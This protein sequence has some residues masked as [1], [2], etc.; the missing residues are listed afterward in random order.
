MFLKT[1]SVRI[2]IVFLL[3]LHRFNKDELDNETSC[4]IRSA[5]MRRTRVYLNK[6]DLCDYVGCDLLS[7][8]VKIMQK[9]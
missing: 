3:L 6:D 7:I 4:V 1:L 9:V 8:L 5:E 2:V